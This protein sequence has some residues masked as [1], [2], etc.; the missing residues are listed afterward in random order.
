M[1]LNVAVGGSWPGSPDASTVFP[2]AM[3]VDYVRVYR[4]AAP[5]VRRPVVVAC[6]P[7]AGARNT[8]LD[9]RVAGDG[10]APGA[11]VSF[12]AGIKVLETT[13]LSATELRVQLKIDRKA[14]PG[15][16]NVTVT[17]PKGRAG[18]GKKVFAVS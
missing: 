6:D 4:P 18:T 2:Q 3:L 11:K 7:A 9:V 15:P 13:V 16:R 17:N 12:G 5:V 8:T 10:F 1:L 14:K